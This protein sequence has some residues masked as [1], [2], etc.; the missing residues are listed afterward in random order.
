MFKR[1][2][3]FGIVAAALGFGVHAIAAAQVKKTSDGCSNAFAVFFTTANAKA[4]EM[5][6]AVD[7]ILRS[8]M[9]EAEFSSIKFKRHKHRHHQDTSA[10]VG[11][12]SSG[13]VCNGAATLIATHRA[14]LGTQEVLCGR[15]PVV[16]E[17]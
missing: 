7:N 14:D 9:P 3:Q 10:Y 15:V 17:E 16:L 8:R 12:C 5:A 1:M 2:A 13:A 4:D 11:N 6:S